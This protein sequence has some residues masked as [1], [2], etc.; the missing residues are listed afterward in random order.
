[1]YRKKILIDSVNV[2]GVGLK[3]FPVLVE[4]RDADLR[5]RAR[6][7]QVG[8]AQGSDIFFTAP[9]G[10]AALAHE[11]E[12]YD[13]ESGAL[14][15]WVRVP[16]L[17]P[18]T[19]T[20]FFICCGASD[21]RP[22]QEPGAV[23]G[24][25][26]RMASSATESGCDHPDSIPL[27]FSDAITVE[28]WIESDS[29]QAEALQA[30]VSKWRISESF[31][32][33]EGHDASNTSG[34]DTR[35]FF[36]AVFDGRYV[37]FVPQNTGSGDDGRSSGHH[38]NVLR[39]DTQGDFKARSSWSAYD[40]S[41]TSGLRTRGYYGAVFDG[42][43][44][45]FIPRTD[46][47]DMHTRLLRYDTHGDFTSARSWRAH[48]VGHPMSCQSAAFD[49]RYIYCCPGYEKDRKTNHCSLMLR[50]DTQGSLT[51]PESYVLHDAANTG[52]L[53]LGCYD[54]GV[55]D[56]RY[57]YFSPLGGIAKMLRYDTHGGFSDKGSWQAF[58][59]AEVSGLK[60]GACVGA[61]FDG[62]YV[63]Y[64]PYANSVAIRFDTR[65]RF[66]DEAAWAAYDA[67][68]TSGLTVKGYD[69]A[70][71]DGRY[72]YFIPFWQG[73]DVRNG[74][75]GVVLRYDTQGDFVDESSWQ[76]ADAGKTSGLDTIG[77]NGGAFDGR[78]I[79]MAPW[80]SGTT[81]AGNP[82]AHGSV[83]RYDTVGEDAS[84]SLRAVDFGHNGGLCGA[85]PG[86]SFLVN[87]AKGIL[88]VRANCNLSPGR[89]HLAG[90]YD[91]RIIT[92][93]V[94]G[95]PVAERS[96]M[97]RIQSCDAKIAIGRIHDGLGRFDGRIQEV[98]I[99]NVARDAG[100]IA[101][102]Y[103]NISSPRSFL[104]IAE[105]ELA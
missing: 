56:G 3:D 60:M 79:Y 27:S 16:E 7:G 19:D 39:Y 4:L 95:V 29:Y 57:V 45:F 1:M 47:V 51:D 55:F 10:D 25:N 8:D 15:A 37:Y 58:D 61:A 99:S 43:Y 94:D 71:F 72:V 68:H 89:H 9:P 5:G 53:D 63:Y 74:F 88:N 2:A 104:R 17:S 92:L 86:P 13:P 105:E 102:L 38:G 85:V 70:I 41:E 44:V 91:G 77:F 49:G 40:A 66:T 48:D 54:G 33:F 35:G 23:W 75:H 34:L 67:G 30:V 65:Q 20:A 96:G 80:R 83:L 81:E 6:G 69:G 64:V 31:D 46:G 103:R 52:G 24:S 87:T 18:E 98:R 73:G 62:R 22:P 84:F 59:A 11:I 14:R 28:A 42:R 101:T 12:A 32:R 50:Y 26:Y 78:F 36:G 82:I 76:A 90:V 97:G 21:S 93:Y 100:W